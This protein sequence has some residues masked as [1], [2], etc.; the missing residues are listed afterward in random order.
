MDALNPTG[1]PVESAGARLARLLRFEPLLRMWVAEGKLSDA[2]AELV[3]LLVVSAEQGR[4]LRV[5]CPGR[6]TRV[7]TLGAIALSVRR[8][9]NL[10]SRQPSGPVGLIGAGLTHR[11]L[12]TELSVRQTSIVRSLTVVRLR[13]DGLVQ[14]LGSGTSRPAET[15]DHL[16]LVSDRVGLPEGVSFGSVLIDEAGAGNAYE[17]L[18]EWALHRSGLVHLVAPLRP[19]N[20]PVGFVADWPLIGTDPGRWP[21]SYATSWGLNPSTTVHPVTPEP[22]GLASARARIAHAAQHLSAPWPEPMRNAAGLCRRL[23]TLA[24]PLE[25][26]DFQTRRSIAVPIAERAEQL[27]AAKPSDLPPAWRSFAETSWAPL[28]QDLLSAIDELES[29]NPKAEEVGMAVE[30]LIG[31][32]DAV[33]IWVDNAVHARALANYLATAGFSIEPEHLDSGVLAVRTFGDPIRDGPAGAAVICGLP[34]SWQLDRLVGADFG[35]PLHV[36]AYPFEQDRTGGRLSWALNGSRLEH[37]AE[38]GRVLRLLLGDVTNEAPPEPVGSATLT[39]EMLI[40]TEALPHEW[41]DDVAEFA[42]LAED[43]WL[44]LLGSEQGRDFEQQGTGSISV[45]ALL[46]EPGP[47]VILFRPAQVLDRMIGGRV[48]PTPAAALTPGMTILGLGADGRSLFDRF[49][50]YLD[51][52][53]GPG[54]RFWLEQ[55]DDAL[56]TAATKVGGP[57]PL[58]E[59][60]SGL[61]AVISHGAVASWASPYRIGPRDPANVSRVARVASHTLVAHHATRVAAVMRGVRVEHHR[62][63]T[64]LVRAVRRHAAGDTEAFDAIEDRVGVDVSPIVTD[65]STYTILQTLGPGTAPAARTRRLLTPGEARNIFCPEDPAS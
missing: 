35:G 31:A 45:C 55:W 44:N 8:L 59:M 17:R 11:Q 57:R 19:S 62:L 28:K 58:A 3:W 65:L 21:Q 26:Y 60:L 49:R 52:I 16:V 34:A 6:M 61:G 50:P 7:A 24:I 29:F 56:Q 1:V 51:G 5:A 42:A 10:G 47:A 36:V 2:E 38:R 12:L 53:H 25:D 14:R 30:R 64:A 37:D 18:H 20:G 54:T 9:T 41:R 63:G 32:G 15:G 27:R 43:Q 33:E 40:R 23:T 48:R 22:T 13:R 46:V 39:S 4:A